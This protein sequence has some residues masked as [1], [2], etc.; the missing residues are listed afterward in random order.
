MFRFLLFPFAVLF[1][2]VTSIRNSL[3]ERGYKPSAS[4]DLPVISVGNLAV[5]GTGKTPMIEYLIRLLSKHY[6]IATL[7]RGYGRE[8]SGIRIAANT[9]SA[10]TIGDE[11]FQLYRKFGESVKVCVGEER[12]LAIPFIIDQA[13]ETEVILL[14]DSFQHRKV[15]PSFQVVLTDYNNL[16]TK[17]W[18]MPVGRLRESRRGI[19]R[20][21]VVVVTKCPPELGNEEMLEIE[22]SIR[23]YTSKPVFFSVIRYGDPVAINTYSKID[24]RV[25]LV[26]GIAN[27]KP[28]EDYVAKHFKLI[29]HFLFP[30]HHSY[31]NEDLKK[32]TAFAEKENAM[33][34]TTEKDAAKLDSPPF[35]YAYDYIPFFYLP[36][37]SEFLKNGKDF[38]EMVLSVVKQHVS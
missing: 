10:S 25:I 1:D 16:F 36:I 30:D 17:D 27:H 5:G 4:F 22:K 14:D 38:D 19:D 8:T 7:S 34:L 29:H 33:V 15:K 13:E 9:D 20:A 31:T 6:K 24:E 3:Y 28:I 37:Q 21:D 18:L 35:A 12:A 2:L 26:T 23:Q 11:P 32:I